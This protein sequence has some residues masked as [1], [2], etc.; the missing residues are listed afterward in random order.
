MTLVG[1]CPI[2]CRSINVSHSESFHDV[3]LRDTKDRWIV[4]LLPSLG[5]YS[6]I[7]GKQVN[8][9]IW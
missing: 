5:T 4:S 8:H 1:V 3:A 2:Q 9:S 6:K 7:P